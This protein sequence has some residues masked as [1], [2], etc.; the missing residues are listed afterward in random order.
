[1]ERGSLAASVG[2]EALLVEEQGHE[3]NQGHRG[4]LNSLSAGYRILADFDAGSV[5]LWQVRMRHC[6]LVF[7][8]LS[9]SIVLVFS[10]VI[11]SAA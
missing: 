5:R 11:G 4:G 6:L 10:A 9:L 8:F 1:M 3:S 2:L 7:V